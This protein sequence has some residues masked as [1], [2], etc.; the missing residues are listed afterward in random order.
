VKFLTAPS[1]EAQLHNN[2]GNKNVQYIVFDL[3]PNLVI[4]GFRDNK[5]ILYGDGSQVI[6][7]IFIFY[8]FFI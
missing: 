8:F 6:I 1:V 4:N 7:F 5:K 3:D 2:N